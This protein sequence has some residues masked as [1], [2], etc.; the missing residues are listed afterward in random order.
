MKAPFRV[1]VEK[2]GVVTLTWVEPAAVPAGV[3][4]RSCVVLTYVVEAL[5]PPT[6]TCEPLLKFWPVIVTCVPPATG[7][8][9]GLMLL[10][11]GAVDVPPGT[12]YDTSVDG[13]LVWPDVL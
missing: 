2:P 4:A 13:A 5:R 10:H 8:D 9:V 6:Q 7:P 12:A 3:V 1:T 11:V